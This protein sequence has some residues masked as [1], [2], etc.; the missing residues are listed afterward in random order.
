MDEEEKDDSIFSTAKRD[1]AW[2]GSDSH[3]DK[4]SGVHSHTCLHLAIHEQACFYHTEKSQK[5]LFDDY[6]DTAG[7][8]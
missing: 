7:V 1:S 2:S 8:V 4:P 6:H 5:A 3:R